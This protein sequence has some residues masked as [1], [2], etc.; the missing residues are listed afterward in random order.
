MPAQ[1]R[2][3]SW[4]IEKKTTNAAY[5]AELMRL[6]TIDIAT[7]LEVPNSNAAAILTQIVH[8]LN[9]LAN[10]YHQNEWTWQWVNVGDEAVGFVWH[11]NNAVAANAFQVDLMPNGGARVWG[12]VRRNTANARIYFPETQTTWGS[13][14]GTPNGRRPAYM[15]FVTNDGAAQRR[16]TV[17]N[18]HTPYPTSGIQAYAASLLATSREVRNV[19]LIDKVA[20]ATAAGIGLSAAMAAMIDP[21]INALF[22]Q[23]FAISQTLRDDAVA[24]AIGEIPADE[25]D[26]AV[27]LRTTA[28]AA[29]SAALDSMVVPAGITNTDG[30]N[31]AR[32]CAMAGV[33]A[34]ATMVASMQLPTAPPAATASA[35]NAR[36]V[37]MGRARTLAGQ[38]A[39]PRKRSTTTYTAAVRLEMQRMVDWAVQPF[40]F[41]ALPLT[42]VDTAIVA[43]DFNV[44]FPDTT[45]YSGA[46]E[47]SLGGNGYNAYTRLLALG[48]GQPNT[49]DTTSRGGSAF[50][51]QRVYRLHIPSPIQSTTPG[52]AT[53][54]PLSMTPLVTTPTSF[55]N[56]TAWIRELVGMARNQGVA[57]KPLRRDPN[58]GTRIDN[59]FD[60]WI[61]N[62]THFYR[63]SCY[64]NFFVRGGTVL[65]CDTIDVL[66]ELG[67]WG[68]GAALVNP[69][70]GLNPNP[71]AAAAGGLNAIAAA[72]LG[73]P[74]TQLQYTYGAAQYAITAPLP[75]ACEAAVFY[76]EWISDHLPVRLEVQL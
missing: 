44:S 43:G 45:L 76:I 64:D 62:N 10:P 15:S 71:W 7:F 19:D 6:H 68:Q 70:P 34:A 21:I 47:T 56:W 49:A 28:H 53:Y 55:V 12:A 31:V 50:R 57:W 30:N 22:D 3:M 40:V 58:Y 37:A 39:P 51:G 35:L 42:P 60:Q 54:V 32:A 75:N 63:A 52:L 29:A 72:E 24:G 16:F 18:L 13:L 20:I 5:V 41:A 74:G 69:Q 26:L 38:F 59:A 65:S 4:N 66:S 17:L 61:N 27:I 48:A 33:G 9:N 73:Q 46:Q 11:Q 36:T 8:E 67:S 1:I 23:T 14:P 25:I 2:V